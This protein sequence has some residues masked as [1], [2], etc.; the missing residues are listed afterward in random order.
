MENV[1]KDFNVENLKSIKKKFSKHQNM[2][3]MQETF[4]KSDE[5]SKYNVCGE[6]QKK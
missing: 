1:K 5:S 4:E 3:R 6:C 2:H